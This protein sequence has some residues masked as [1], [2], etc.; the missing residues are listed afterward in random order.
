METVKNGIAGTLVDSIDLKTF[1]VG[2]HDLPNES[3]DLIRDSV[4]K[5]SSSQFTIEMRLQVSKNWAPH[6]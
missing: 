1:V 4:E 2:F 5:F 3:T 6:Q